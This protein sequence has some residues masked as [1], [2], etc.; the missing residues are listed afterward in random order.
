MKN[1]KL[2]IFLF[3]VSVICLAI[4]IPTHWELMTAAFL[5]GYYLILYSLILAAIVIVPWFL[6]A[7]CMWKG[8]IDYA[9]CVAEIEDKE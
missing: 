7:L 8:S 1:K 9:N 5:L 3:I 2:E 6:I 4:Y